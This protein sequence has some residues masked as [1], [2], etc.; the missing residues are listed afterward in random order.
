MLYHS[1]LNEKIPTVGSSEVFRS[2][3]AGK[4]VEHLTRCFVAQS[5]IMPLRT[6]AHIKQVISFLQ[7]KI[8]MLFL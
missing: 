5:E 7:L 4:V 1:K 8:L 2:T 6:V 3:G